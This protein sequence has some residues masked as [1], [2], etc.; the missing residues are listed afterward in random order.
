[1]C[2]NRRQTRAAMDAAASGESAENC[3]F[4][5]LLP[6][7][8][9]SAVSDAAQM[10][11]FRYRVE[12]RNHSKTHALL[13]LSRRW[14]FV[15]CSG[16]REV[17]GP[18]FA[19]SCP[20]ILPG[21]SHTYESSAFV[22]LIVPSPQQ[23]QAHEPASP[24]RRRTPVNSHAVSHNQLLGVPSTS[25]AG[26][27][28][29]NGEAPLSATSASFRQLQDFTANTDGTVFAAAAQHARE[30][31]ATVG[32]MQGAF[33]FVAVPAEATFSEEG[34]TLLRKQADRAAG[35]KNVPGG[36]AAPGAGPT[37]FKKFLRRFY[38]SSAV[39]GAAPDMPLR[40]S[41]VRVVPTA[42]DPFLDE[43]TVMP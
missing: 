42:L 15:G 14:Q 7:A 24:G 29:P 3:F 30:F 31:G 25:A 43:Y 21:S 38:D 27:A 11:R 40:V 37:A 8:S 6:G 16:M 32:W 41:H 18:G 10:L 28:T 9:S 23:L 34:L 20:L 5:A 26:A 12:M 35:S 1:M 19:G 13:M 17:V 22:P 33:Q 36:S 2:M 39:A 4:R